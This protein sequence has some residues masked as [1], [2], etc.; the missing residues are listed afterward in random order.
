MN[1]MNN[2][3]NMYNKINERVSNIRN[4]QTNKNKDELKEVTNKL[5]ENLDNFYEK[6]YTEA[7][8]A[9]KQSEEEKINIK[10]LLD[11]LICNQ[12]NLT[13]KY[14]ETE[15]NF[16]NYKMTSHICDFIIFLYNTKSN[17]TFDDFIKSLSECSYDKHYNKKYIMISLKQYFEEKN[18]IKEQTSKTLL[19]SV[20]PLSSHTN[21]SSLNTVDANNQSGG[22]I[23]LNYILNSFTEI[24]NEMESAVSRTLKGEEININSLLDIVYYKYPDDYL[25]DSI[26]DFIVS[27]FKV[28][29]V[30]DFLKFL[31]EKVLKNY[32]N[33]KGREVIIED[34]FTQKDEVFDNNYRYYTLHE[35]NSPELKEAKKILQPHFYEEYSI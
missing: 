6:I 15:K 16:Y 35:N 10:I 25:I 12:K 9:V 17:K 14:E 28:Q 32:V 4:I 5:H 13:E 22:S 29:K 20:V 19:S 34:I 31:S 23:F 27:L 21:S 1:K 18:L 33:K 8:E 2:S 3:K 24:V 26:Q 11:I 30:Q 7:E